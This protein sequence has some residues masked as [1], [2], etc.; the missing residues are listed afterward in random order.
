MAIAT[1]HLKLPIDKES[2]IGLRKSRDM[3]KSSY[4]V[5]GTMSHLDEAEKRDAVL[6]RIEQNLEEPYEARFFIAT[7][8]EAQGIEGLEQKLSDHTT[9]IV[10]R[11]QNDIGVTVEELRDDELL[12]AS[13]NFFPG[14]QMA[15]KSSQ[16]RRLNP[17]TVLSMDLVWQNPL[18]ARHLP[19][20]QKLLRG[21]YIGKT[22]E[23]I[24]VCWNPKIVPSHHIT[25]LDPMGTGKTTFIKSF[26]YRAHL[27]LGI[28]SWIF[29]V[30]GE[31][32]PFIRELGGTIIDLKEKKV[33]PF[34]LNGADP[35]SVANGIAEM[36]TYLAGLRG[37]ERFYFRTII[38]ELY[39]KYGVDAD[40]AETWT[41][42][43][44]NKVNFETLHHHLS[45]KL[46]SGEIKAEDL[47]LARGV[48]NKIEVF[49]IGAYRIGK[50]D[51]T[52]DQ[53]Y[54][55]E[56][57][58]CFLL[59]GLPEYLQKALV[60]SIL[61]QTNT[62]FYNRYK[63]HEELQ[64]MIVVEEAHLFSKPVPADLPGGKIEP[65][66]HPV[67]DPFPD[68]SMGSETPVHPEHP[69]R[70]SCGSEGTV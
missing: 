61:E 30:A 45:D 47:N 63:I 8:A 25:V 28:P 26:T 69:P 68:W 13:R 48:L 42:Q 17:L 6:R 37:D 31:Y 53:L 2:L 14:A 52:L 4:D 67:E 10:N 62:L 58:V 18:I 50:A 59:K 22:P 56:K 33:N 36:L 51:L 46:K 34:V 38:T 7:W 35:V 3:Y 66:P 32:A 20:L 9:H 12:E 21:V 1:Y 55:S 70:P 57:P 43:A 44:S 16:S 49:S 39:E 15:L 5:G 41:D 19:P 27:L 54:R 64:L 29:D 11:F 23:G 65:H 60:W 24:P 40:S